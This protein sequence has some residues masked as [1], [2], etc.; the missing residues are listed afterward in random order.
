[1]GEVGSGLGKEEEGEVDCVFVEGRFIAF[2]SFIFCFIN[3]DSNFRFV[4]ED[5]EV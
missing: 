1:M 2:F 5:I 4:G 3:G